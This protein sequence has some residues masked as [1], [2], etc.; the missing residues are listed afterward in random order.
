MT[1]IVVDFEKQKVCA[2]T[3]TTWTNEN[4]A[5]DTVHTRETLTQKINVCPEKRATLVSIGNT[6][7]SALFIKRYPHHMDLDDYGHYA[8]DSRVLVI[9][10]VGSGL[11]VR[12][13]SFKKVKLGWFHSLLVSNPYVYQP[14]ESGLF[15]RN[16]GK[17]EFGSGQQYAEAVGLY[18]DHAEAIIE[19]V[20]LLDPNTNDKIQ[21]VLIET[22]DE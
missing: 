20:S 19:K 11:K 6:D 1:T 14:Y 18:E 16:F 12:V 9:T 22:F 10:K 7:P 13:F 21:T 17:V 4:R 5:G 8:L 3:Q 15:L 2:D